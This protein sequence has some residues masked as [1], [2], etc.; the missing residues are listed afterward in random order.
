M[1]DT[2]GL[3]IGL[4]GIQASQQAL[5]IIGENIANA[6]TPGYVEE[7]AVLGTIGNP[8]VPGN[9][10]GVAVTSIQRQSNQYLQQQ[11]L[12]AQSTNQSLSAVQSALSTIQA[13]FPEPAGTGAFSTQLAS[14][15]SDWG[16]LS[17]NAGNTSARTALLQQGQVVAQ[18]LNQLSAGISSVGT[19]AGQ[20]LTSAVS[21]VNS[22]A[23]QIATLNGRIVAS[24]AGTG[25]PD[26]GLQDQRDTLVS[27]LSQQLDIQVTALPGGSE[28]ITAGNGTLVTGT[29]TQQL[30]LSGG[31]ASTA[32]TWG[33]A[34]TSAAVTGGAV[35]GLLTVVTSTVPGQLA[36]LDSV[37]SSL[38]NAVNTAQAQGYDLTGAKGK[39][40]FTGSTAADLAVAITDPN[41]IAA[42]S[43]PV[44]SG[45][46]PSANIDGS[47][48]ANIADLG[49]GP[50]TFGGTSVASPTT[51]YGSF[52]A[53]LG[54]AVSQVNSQ[55]S[56][57]SQVVSSTTTTYQNQT[58]VDT[59]Q[60]LTA[61]V[62]YQNSYQAAAR[63]LTT[64]QATMQDLLQAVG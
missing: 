52:V 54:S 45:T 27:K 33:T 61:M 13:Q 2:A 28:T 1:S 14:F 31:G 21:T 9:D 16:S 38:S 22:L 42:A 30:T 43:T 7:Q 39:P 35:G 64:V 53:D 55:V 37:A 59:N 44:P 23:S 6:G 18:S 62:Q 63:F 50:V 29:A 12:T 4:S 5:N 34:G 46:S 8:S 25:N 24:S 56:A 51:V 3:Y 11:V 19:N 57:Q 41:Q 32:L 47:N 58:G 20:Q 15:W 40:F 17:T 60:E 48:A 26:P 36:G 10:A 49:A